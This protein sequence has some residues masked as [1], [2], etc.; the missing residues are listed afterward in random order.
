MLDEARYPKIYQQFSTWGTEA[1]Y[2]SYFVTT[3]IKTHYM[4]NE[5]KGNEKK[6]KGKER[7]G[8]RIKEK[9]KSEKLKTVRLSNAFSERESIAVKLEEEGKMHN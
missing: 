2:G 7:K 1:D 9:V 4:K 3:Y 5:K 6:R 8:N